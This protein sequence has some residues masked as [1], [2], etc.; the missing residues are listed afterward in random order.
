[1]IRRYPAG[2]AGIRNIGARLRSRGPLTLVVW[3]CFIL[4]T[5]L[6]SL[7]TSNYLLVRSAYR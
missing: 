6:L 2:G 4:I 7:T 3:P 5:H 1:M